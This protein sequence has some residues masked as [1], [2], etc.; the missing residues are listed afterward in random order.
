MSAAPRQETLVGTRTRN[1]VWF[2]LSAILLCH[3]HGYAQSGPQ[4]P[5]GSDPVPACPGLDDSAIVK[6]WTA[7]TSKSLP[8]G[9]TRGDELNAPNVSNPNPPARNKALAIVRMIGLT[10]FVP[11]D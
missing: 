6:S 7:S 5:C 3:V 11:A 1:R 4:P 9:T 2:V 8:I 10:R